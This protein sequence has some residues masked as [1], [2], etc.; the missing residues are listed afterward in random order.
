MIKV[1]I[2]DD[3]PLVRQGIKALLDV[4]EDIE[5]TG[6]A[7]NGR[8]AIEMCKNY[9]P[10]IVLM[11]LVM[12]EVSGIEATK[13]VL[14]YW[15]TIKIII[16]TSFI[17]KKL[18]KDAFKAGAIGYVLKNISGNNLVESIRD[19]KKGKSPL[20]SEASDFLIS[21]FKEPSPADYQLTNQE[22]NILT[23]LINGLSNKKIAQVQVLSLSTVKFHVSNILS[24]LGVSSRAEA[25]SVALNNKL[26]Q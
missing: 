5:V 16:L 2:V 1:L 19:A 20:S 22:I 23:H 15:P 6:D 17:D 3:H 12:P 10:D 13:E 11:D 4:Y 26:I 24:K 25:I 14:K 8:E 9:K 7:E 21:N 18:I